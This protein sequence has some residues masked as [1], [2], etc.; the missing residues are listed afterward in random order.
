MIRDILLTVR[1]DT[2][3]WSRYKTIFSLNPRQHESYGTLPTKA[4]SNRS[5][6]GSDYTTDSV[7]FEHFKTENSAPFI[8][9]ARSHNN[10]KSCDFSAFKEKSF[11]KLTEAPSVQVLLNA[12]DLSRSPKQP[13]SQIEDLRQILLGEIDQGAHVVQSFI[14]AFHKKFDQDFGKEL[15]WLHN[16]PTHVKNVKKYQSICQLV[17]AFASVTSKI[18]IY[19]HQDYVGQFESMV[20][21]EF[22]EPKWVAET[23]VYEILFRNPNSTL[24]VLM[25]EHLKRMHDSNSD[26]LDESFRNK[27]FLTFTDSKRVKISPQ[28]AMEEISSVTVDGESNGTVEADLFRLDVSR[29][30]L[31]SKFDA[32]VNIERRIFQYLTNYY[33]TDGKLIQNIAGKVSLDSDLSLTRR[34]VKELQKVSPIVDENYM[35][36]YIHKQYL[37]HII[38]FRVLQGYYSDPLSSRA[39]RL[40][41]S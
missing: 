30:G 26:D 32:L 4:D 37:D 35:E 29:M 36:E 18:I 8:K 14:D 31:Y 19:I 1:K 10:S 17:K 28:F 12:L 13:K 20:E 9:R 27:P 40:T 38:I 34:V 21:E 5:F 6:E 23:V 16:T 7:S 15:D 2:P 41:F 11:S 25:L 39:E 24:N 3:Y 33:L 22:F